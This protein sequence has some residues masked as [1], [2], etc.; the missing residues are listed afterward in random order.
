M[1]KSN[2]TKLGYYV[3]A[4]WSLGF[5]GRYLFIWQD[6]SQAVIYVG[7]GLGI[8][9]FS[10]VYQ[11]ILE[12]IKKL[13]GLQDTQFETDD[14]LKSEGIIKENL[15]EPEKINDGNKKYSEEEERSK[16]TS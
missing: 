1:E 8:M 3:G 11:K 9:A 14:I 5:A 12:I 10:W 2:W 16:D 13:E 6:Y 15:I 7:Y 4:F